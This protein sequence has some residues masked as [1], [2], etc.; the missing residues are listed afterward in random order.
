MSGVGQSR[1]IDDAGDMS[2][3]PST[4][5]ELACRSNNGSGHKQNFKLSLFEIRG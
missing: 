5:S 3:V 4:A 2:G 1:R